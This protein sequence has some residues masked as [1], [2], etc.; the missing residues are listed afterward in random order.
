M[1]LAI[2]FAEDEPGLRLAL[3]DALRR[4]GHQ[5]LVAEDGYQARALLAGQRIDA[6]VLD[7]RLPGPN[8]LELLSVLRARH[9]EAMVV[10]ISAYGSL[11]DLAEVL[12]SEQVRFLH[13]PFTPADVLTL[14][15]ELA[16]SAALPSRGSERGLVTVS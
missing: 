4:A 1:S 2:L 12:E 7:I 6:A 5:A 8:G 13:K 16:D 11:Y 14:L 3:S 15:D 9:P 10:L